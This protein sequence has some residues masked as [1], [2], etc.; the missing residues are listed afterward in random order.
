MIEILGKGLTL[1]PIIDKLIQSFRGT[2]MTNRN[3]K[4]EG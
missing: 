4:E 2:K 3:E 1:A